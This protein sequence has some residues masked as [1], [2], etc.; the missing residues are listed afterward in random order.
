MGKGLS[1][2]LFPQKCLQTFFIFLSRAPRSFSRARF[3][4]ELADVFEKNEQKNKTMSVYRL[5]GA[6]G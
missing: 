6:V 5:P 4:R 3:A 2:P 1:K